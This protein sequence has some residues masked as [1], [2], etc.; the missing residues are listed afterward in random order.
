MAYATS[1]P[2][3]TADQ[4]ASTWLKHWMLLRRKL[5]SLE[6]LQS[7]SP[8]HT[9]RTVY[10]ATQYQRDFGCATRRA[11][12]KQERPALIIWSA[13]AARG[14]EQCVSLNGVIAESLVV[15]RVCLR[16][17]LS[18]IRRRTTRPACCRMLRACPCGTGILYHRPHEFAK[19]INI[20]ILGDFK[21]FQM[22]ACVI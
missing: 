11:G 13:D 20:P 5:H 22:M 1:L 6:A 4:L 2:H 14:I 9:T 17:P 16:A 21:T 12:K 19:R 3:N 8:V 18:T 10:S 7:R 15:P